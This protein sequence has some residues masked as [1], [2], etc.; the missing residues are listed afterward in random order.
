MKLQMRKMVVALLL[1]AM[2]CPTMTVQAKQSKSNVEPKVIVIDPKGQEKASKKKE[3]IGPGALKISFEATTGEEGVETG[4]KEYEM[5][6]QIAL[7]LQN[8]LEDQGYTVYLTR[9][10]ND[11]NISNSGRAMIA[12]IADADAFV[13]ISASD[14]KGIGVICQSEDNPYN[15]GNYR[16]SRLLADTILGSLVQ[17]SDED[18]EVEE[19]D[20]MPL[21]NWCQA[22]TAIVQVGDLE[23]SSD[24]EKLVTDDYQD[25]LAE[26]IACGIES[27]FAQK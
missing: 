24:E 4:Y 13:V 2:L 1:V 8:A 14:E 5:N 25:Q 22:P 12:N 11:V 18:G 9:D 6:L 26:A 27:Y 10:E 17:K 16:N 23:D 19:S 7:K 15:Y 21:I 3:P 20:D